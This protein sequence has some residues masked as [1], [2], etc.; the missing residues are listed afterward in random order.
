VIVDPQDGFSN[1]PNKT[2]FNRAFTTNLT[3]FEWF[4]LPEHAHRMARFNRA[5]EGGANA[6]APAT[7]TEG[8][9]RNRIEFK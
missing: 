3:L 2:A 4:N 7:V 9:G 1:A 8:L 5:M 6:M